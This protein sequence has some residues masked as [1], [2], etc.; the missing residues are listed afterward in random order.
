MS[1]MIDLFRDLTTRLSAELGA[2]VDRRYMPRNNV[3]DLDTTKISIYIEATEREEVARQIDVERF[4]F[5]IAVQR[6]VGDSIALDSNSQPVLDGI[7]NLA[8]GD[9]V[10]NRMEDIKDLFRADGVLRFEQIAGCSFLEMVHEPPYEP[11]A[12][13]AMGIYT[14]ILDVTYQSA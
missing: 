10:L 13:L 1:V 4:T 5:G 2:T 11:I 12:L 14:A 9:E 6:A 7:D 3:E 8:V